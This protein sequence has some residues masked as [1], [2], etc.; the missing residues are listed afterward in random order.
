MDIVEME[1]RTVKKKITTLK[2][3]TDSSEASASAMVNE[4]KKFA[5]S[6]FKG[7]RGSH[8]WEHTLRVGRLCERIG[9]AEDAD[10]TVLMIAAYL[11]DIGRYDQDRSKGAV[12]H[13]QEGVKIAGPMIASLPLAPERKENIVHC[14]RSH[15]FRGEN[16]PRTREARVLFDADKLDAIGAVGV[17]RAFLFAGEV[18]AALHN[19]GIDIEQ[20]RPYS[21]DDTGYREYKVK[22]SKISKRI[23]TAEGR[24]LARRRHAFM[25]NFFDRFLEEFEGKG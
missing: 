17:A 8:D 1:I 6:Y 2:K 7:V 13:A 19:P 16:R 22:L 14:I 15:R 23:L 10:M 12:C 18:G 4:V 3:A 11:H 24:R 21:R 25:K 20:T 9:S 5:Q